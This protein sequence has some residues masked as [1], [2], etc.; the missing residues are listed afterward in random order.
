MQRNSKEKLAV[1]MPTTSLWLIFSTE[2]LPELC[3]VRLF[4]CFDGFDHSTLI[5]D[6]GILA[7]IEQARLDSQF[8]PRCLAICVNLSSVVSESGT[9]EISRCQ[10]VSCRLLNEGISLAGVW[11][12]CSRG[13]RCDLQRTT[14]DADQTIT[15]SKFLVQGTFLCL[16][17]RAL[18]SVFIPTS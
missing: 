18:S 15:N 7:D 3:S 12:N 13:V 5:I 4:T 8:L 16:S 10:T 9:Q 11:S 2:Y 6:P 17:I 1:A 14:T